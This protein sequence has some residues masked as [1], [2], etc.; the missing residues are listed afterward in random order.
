VSV[1]PQPAEWNSAVEHSRA[2]PTH[3]LGPYED[4]DGQMHME[5]NGDGDPNEPSNCG[6]V[7][8]RPCQAG[9]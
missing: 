7:T 1:L 4:E 3:I 6:F 9:Q 2:C 5:C 8:V